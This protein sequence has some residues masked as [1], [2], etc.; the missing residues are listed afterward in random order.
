[1]MMMMVVV[2]VVVVVVMVVVVVVVIMTMMIMKKKKKKKMMMMM[3]TTTTTMPMT[4]MHD[5]KTTMLA[6][7]ERPTILITLHPTPTPNVRSSPPG[8][9]RGSDSSGRAAEV[10]T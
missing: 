1:M 3:T 9:N 2:V 4:T 8:E 7:K 5:V 10:S 6:A